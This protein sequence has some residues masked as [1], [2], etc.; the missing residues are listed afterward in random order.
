MNRRSLFALLWFIPL[1]VFGLA[2]ETAPTPP[3][4]KAAPRTLRV[5]FIGNSYTYVND[6]PGTTAQLLAPRGI[7]L[8][9][10]SVTPGGVTL[11]KQW[12]DG[13]ALAAIQKGKWDYV[14]LQEQ[15]TRPFK[16][17][18]AMFQSARLF[19]AEIAK[20]GAKTLLYETWA[21]KATPDDQAKLTESYEMLG[22]ELGA[23]VVP[24]GEAWKKALAAGIALHGPDG[25]HP[26]RAGTYLNACLFVR[27]LTKEMPLLLPDTGTEKGKAWT[28]PEAPTLQRI[29][30]ETP[31][32]AVTAAAAQPT[33]K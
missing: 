25:R 10:E 20:V 32:P 33:A 23:T 11:E 12:A 26:A 4:G 17:R 31:V 16:D 29:A 19:H 2:G 6:L 30:G 7:T 27:A 13:K 15:S 1:T 28:V 18:A 22:R 9:H 8:E 24:A 21:T 5:L 14:V 3:A